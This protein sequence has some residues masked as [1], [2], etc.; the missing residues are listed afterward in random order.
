LIVSTALVLLA[1]AARAMRDT[2]Y[3]LASIVESSDD[4]VVTKDLNGVVQSWNR[5]A[6]RLFGYAPHE[7]IGQPILLLIPP[8]HQH[9]EHDILTRLRKG[10]RIDHFETVR[11][12]KNGQKVDVSLTV[13]PVRN[14]FGDIIGASKI[15]R[16][17]SDR[18]RDAE[19]RE[20]LLEAERDARAEAEQANRSK[21][22]FVAMVSHELRTPLNAILGWTQILKTGPQDAETLS[23]AIDVIERNARAQEKV[24]SDLLDMSRV[25]SGKLRLDVSDVDLIALIK[26]AVEAT[27][28]AAD[29]KGIS[30][31]C[32]LDPSLATT[33][34]DP[35]RLEQCVWNLLSNAIKFT[36]QGGRVTVAM[37]LAGSHVEIRVSDTGSGISPEFLPFVFD[38]FRQLESAPTRRS[39]GLGLGLAIVKQLA[40]LHGGY[41]RAESSGEGKGSTFAIALPVRALRTKPSLQRPK[42]DRPPQLDRVRVLLVEDEADNRE[43]LRTLLEQHRAVVSV[44]G[45]AHEALQIMP[46]VRPNI[47]VSDI[48]LPDLD[49]YELVQRIRQSDVPPA[50]IPAIALTA[51]ASSDDRTK[52]LRAGFQAHI[53]KPV[54]PNELVATIASL[55]GLMSRDQLPTSSA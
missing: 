20:C 6:Q 25:I 18:K 51:H 10:E 30:V 49:G 21:D 8:E 12:K 45:S 13:S 17:I 14:K 16:D 24:V 50:R 1:R 4:A 40:E 36:P 5:G 42:S 15:A 19:E 22:E 39:A 53:A 54:E 7:I 2:Q 31:D 35:T 47:V 55:T 3:F 52:A 32:T 33:V 38:R 44:A 37:R 41:A 48:G 26:S 34:G 29:A 27:R 28:P 43:V 11:L 23:K 46:S 9:E